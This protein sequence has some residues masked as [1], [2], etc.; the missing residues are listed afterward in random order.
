MLKKLQQLRIKNKLSYEEMA[1][2]VNLSKAYYWQIEHGDRKLSYQNAITISK[3]FNLKPDDIFY[4]DYTKS[5]E[6]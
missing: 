3:V 6:K 2:K 5:L 1:K 4:E